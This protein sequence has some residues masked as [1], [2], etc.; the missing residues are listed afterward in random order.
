MPF[1]LEGSPTKIFYREKGTQILTSLLEDL[2]AAFSSQIWLRLCFVASLWI[3]GNRFHYW[4]HLFSFFS[5]GTK[6][7]ATGGRERQTGARSTRSTRGSR[8]LLLLGDQRAVPGRAESAAQAS[9][10]EFFKKQRG[11]H[12]GPKGKNIGSENGANLDGYFVVF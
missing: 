9:P 10:G 2:E 1:F 7:H 5:Q 4:T 12:R 6:T 11:L 3:K 8:H